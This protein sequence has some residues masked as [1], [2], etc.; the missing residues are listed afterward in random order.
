MTVGAVNVCSGK[1]H[2]FDTRK[3]PLSADHVMASGALPPA[4]GAV[5]TFRQI[6]TVAEA[7]AFFRDARARALTHAGR[8][9]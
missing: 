8:T 2:Y 4:F 6:G 3:Q 1:M 7:A 5:R 9:A